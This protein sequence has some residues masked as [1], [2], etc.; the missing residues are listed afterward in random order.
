MSTKRTTTTSHKLLHPNRRLNGSTETTR[1]Q[2][3]AARMA[4]SGAQ[5][6]VPAPL[7]SKTEPNMRDYWQGFYTVF[8]EGP[9]SQ[10][11]PS[12][13]S[14]AETDATMLAI[15]EAGWLAHKSTRS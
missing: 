7:P 12:Y 14:K 5:T 1:A 6:P 11:L 3:H 2:A 9:N 13:S 4:H 15:F 10:R 8:L